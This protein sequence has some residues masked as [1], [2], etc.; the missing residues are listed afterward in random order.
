MSINT[1]ILKYGGSEIKVNPIDNLLNLNEKEYTE[2]AIGPQETFL[3]SLEQVNYSLRHYHV[4]EINTYNNWSWKKGDY[5]KMRHFIHNKLDLNKKP[6]NMATLLDRTID[7]TNYLNYIARQ[8]RTMERQRAELRR[9]GV[10]KNINIDE[11]T[12]KCSNLISNINRECDTLYDYSEGK[13]EMKPY[14][15][16]NNRHSKFYLDIIMRDLSLSITTGDSNKIIQEIPIN[17]LR[18]IVTCNFRQYLNNNLTEY[19]MKG[20][21]YEKLGEYSPLRFPYISQMYSRSYDEYSTVCLDKFNDDIKKGFRNYKYLDMGISLMNWA[22]LYNTQYSNP[23]NKPHLMHIGLPKSYSEEYKATLNYTDVTNKCS[24]N[25]SAKLRD[26][27]WESYYSDYYKEKF[28]YCDS[29][30]CQLKMDCYWHTST[31]ASLVKKSLLEFQQGYCMIES[32]VGG[33]IE[34]LESIE[35]EE[36]VR[37]EFVSRNV[38]SNIFERI[39]GRFVSHDDNYWLNQTASFYTFLV[40]T[41][42]PKDNDWNFALWIEFATTTKDIILKLS[43]YNLDARHLQDVTIGETKSDNDDLSDEQKEILK[44]TIAFAMGR[45]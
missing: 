31:M 22:Q 20:R 34:Y 37:G 40:T 45:S 36:T 42:I 35:A 21:Y 28:K 25:L 1:T 6:K 27:D 3:E 14:F 23:Y 2:L 13:V 24:D 44:K 19:S 17:I 18:I 12:T 5:D 10:S 11:F 7:K 4:P 38:I 43:G 32:Y 41:P 33:I 39:V 26:N 15:I 16:F 30:E 9:I 8:V 29:I